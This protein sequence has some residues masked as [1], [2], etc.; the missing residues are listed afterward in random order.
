MEAQLAQLRQQ[1]ESVLGQPPPPRPPHAPPPAYG[2]PLLAPVQLPPLGLGLG[3]LLLPDGEADE[4]DEQLL[5]AALTWHAER[6]R[7]VLLHARVSAELRALRIGPLRT[8]TAGAA[9]AGKSARK[10]ALMQRIAALDAELESL[11]HSCVNSGGASSSALEEVEAALTGRLHT[12]ELMMDWRDWSAEM[13]NTHRT[14][15]L[16]LLHRAVLDQAAAAPIASRVGEIDECTLPPSLT[17]E[18]EV[19][20]ALDALAGEVGLPALGPIRP[21]RY[22]ACARHFENVFEST[23]AR[24]RSPRLEGLDE[25]AKAKARAGVE[26]SLAVRAR[27]TAAAEAAAAGAAARIAKGEESIL[28]ETLHSD[29]MPRGAQAEYTDSKGVTHHVIIVGGNDRLPRIEFEDPTTRRVIAYEVRRQALVPLGGKAQLREAAAATRAAI[30]RRNIAEEVLAAANDRLQSA[31]NGPWSPRSPR[32]PKFPNLRDSPSEMEPPEAA[33]PP[34]SGVAPRK[35][36]VPQ[37]GM[38]SR[39]GMG[40]VRRM[41]RPTPFSTRESFHGL[42][43]AIDGALAAERG[44]LD[45]VVRPSGWLR[46]A[47]ILAYGTE[48]NSLERAWLER[49]PGGDSAAR[50]YLAM[51]REQEVGPILTRIAASAREYIRELSD[52]SASASWRSR[53]RG[54]PVGKEDDGLPEG[55]AAAA[56]LNLRFKGQTR[57]GGPGSTLYYR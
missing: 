45:V 35:D 27:E 51:I 13:A 46:H 19:E 38:A 57:S 31:D 9:D 53:S 32:S 5:D 49:Q 54:R 39:R 52:Q 50:L 20:A 23:R 29:P 8:G 28:R 55:K 56:T 36:V 24:L 44:E 21:E 43:E 41:S 10:D 12:D 25:F 1:I 47:G 6:R 3:P 34:R 15:S 33:P 40:L 37:S 14:H 18:A 16:A 2:E 4:S 11:T 30:E 48:T 7:H 22:R 26:R 42:S 17:T